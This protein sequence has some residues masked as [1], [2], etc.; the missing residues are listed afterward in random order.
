MFRN[1]EVVRAVPTPSADD[2]RPTREDRPRTYR[3]PELVEVGTTVELVRRDT[4]GDY[5]ETW[6]GWRTSRV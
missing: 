6:G 1:E 5:L 3:A 4:L 2:P